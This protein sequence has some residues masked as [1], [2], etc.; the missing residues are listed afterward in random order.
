VFEYE[1]PDGEKGLKSKPTALTD[2]EINDKIGERVFDKEVLIADGVHIEADLHGDEHGKWD[3]P[4]DPYVAQYPFNHVRESES[5]HVEEWDDSPD[6]E[7]L[8]RK[9]KSGTFEEI[10]PDGQTVTKIVS[11]NYRIVMGDEFIHIKKDDEDKRGNVNITVEGSA[12]LRIVKDWNVEVGG[13]VNMNIP[14]FNYSQI[15]RTFHCDINVTSLIFIILFYVYKFITH[16]NSIIIR[17]DLCY[18]LSIWMNLFKRSR[19]MFTH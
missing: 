14:I 6:G 7:R 16:N 5:G 15:S 3:E 12:N 10:H 18:C 4:E 2:T 11:D 17:N 19:L 8:M 13:G 9:H 1:N